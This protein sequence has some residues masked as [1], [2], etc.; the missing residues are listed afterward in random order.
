MSEHIGDL[1]D[2]MHKYLCPACHE[3]AREVAR[4]NFK[5]RRAVKMSDSF[6]YIQKMVKFAEGI[7]GLA[8]EHGVMPKKPG[9]KAASETTTKVIKRKRKVKAEKP[10]QQASNGADAQQEES[11]G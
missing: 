5:V 6:E 9:R 10:A 8:Q 2:P 1:D 7:I 3:I 11:N 4:L